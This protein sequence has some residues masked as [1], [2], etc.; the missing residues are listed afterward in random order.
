[1]GMLTNAWCE[2]GAVMSS[3]AATTW[4][5]AHRP[6]RRATFHSGAGALNRPW[7][8]TSQMGRPADIAA[9]FFAQSMVRM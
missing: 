1:M 2:T 9:A 6:P 5:P 7:C 3:A 8:A 4:M